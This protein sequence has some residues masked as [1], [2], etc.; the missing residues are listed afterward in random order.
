[1]SYECDS[2]KYL[3]DGF[4]KSF[5]RVMCFCCCETYKFCSSEGSS[6]CDEQIAE[7]LEP[8]MEGSWTDPILAADVAAM[9]I[10]STVYHNSENDEADDCCDFQYG[11][12][13]L[14]F[15]VGFDATE[16]DGYYDE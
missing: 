6:S 3:L 13:V 1:M 11:E 16:I 9:W 7:T 5:A 15:A 4:W 8:I 12:T 2:P 14:G 10:S